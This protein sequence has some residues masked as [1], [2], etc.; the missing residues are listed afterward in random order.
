MPSTDYPFRKKPVFKVLKTDDSFKFKNLPEP[1]GLYP[2]RL[3]IENIVKPPQKTKLTFH[4]A[5]DTGSI[6]ESLVQNVISGEMAKQVT[7]ETSEQDKP[8]FLYH[9]G[10]V[11]YKYGEAENYYQQFFKPFQVYPAPIFAIAGNHDS[12][13]NPESEPYESLNAFKQVFCDSESKF[14]AFDT[15]KCRKSMVQP[16]IYWTLETPLANFI[17]LHSNVPKFGA[18]T[19][20]QRAWFIDELKNAATQQPKKV[21]IIC[22]HH[23]PYSADTNHGSSLAMIEFFGK[24][25]EETGIKPDL[26]FSGHVHNYQRFNKTYPDGKVVPH[27]VSGAGG[28]HELHSIAPLNSPDFPDTSPLFDS[29]TLE[30]YAVGQHGFLR[31]AIEKQQSNYLIKVQYFTIPGINDLNE[32]STASLF[33]EFEVVV[34][35]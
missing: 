35:S 9:L 8:L 16:N 26:V 15:D 17:G 31:V 11:V 33:D 20:E 27:V 5:G 34:N 28:Y 29:V 19:E 6:Y 25:F 12:D 3:N 18:I 32:Q 2:Y 10:D 30:K 13:I 22:V 1:T 4:M 7:Q 14:V 23:A 21:L 24:A